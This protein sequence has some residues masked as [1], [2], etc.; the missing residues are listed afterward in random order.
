[1]VMLPSPEPKLKVALATLPVV[2]ESVTL[3]WV[4]A[5]VTLMFTGTEAA[6]PKFT[7]LTCRF[8]TVAA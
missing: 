8:C 4:A 6:P 5:A 2:S 7:W 1:M 3:A